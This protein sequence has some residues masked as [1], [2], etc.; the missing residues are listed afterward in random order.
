MSKFDKIIK[1]CSKSFETDLNRKDLNVTLL[2]AIAK[3][4]GPSIYR[5]DTAKVACSDPK[6]LD[7]IK[8]NFLMK[9]LG[10]EDSPSLDEALQAVCD[11]MGSSNRNKYRVLFYY[12]LVEKFG[13][14]DL[15][16]DAVGEPKTDQSAES[17][18]QSSDK[19][20][21][22]KADSD[23]MS[24]PEKLI[25]KYGIYAAF[26]GLVPIP[27]IDLASITAVQYKMIK[28]LTTFYPHVEFDEHRTKTLIG[29]L[30]GGVGSF[31]LGLFA[32]LLFKGVPIIGPV[33]G[34]TAMSGFAYASTR[35]V[36]NIFNEHF[37]SGG[38]L[39]LEDITYQKMKETYRS[40]MNRM[41]STFS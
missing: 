25:H 10:L 22:Q 31:E 6:E 38:D 17:Q 23:H 36:G 1:K 21:R 12:L 4:L 8:K 37:E 41:K 14:Q 29:A 2:R 13:K 28:K 30:I 16:V 24:T 19:K 32:R 20:S 40:E 33:I 27:L 9:K 18:T 3:S 39:S 5:N 34:G 26:G 35:V 7:R 15:F 11:E